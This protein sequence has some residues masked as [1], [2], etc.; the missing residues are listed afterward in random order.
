MSATQRFS[1]N[2]RQTEAYAKPIALRGLKLEP[3]HKTKLKL[4]SEINRLSNTSL[5]AEQWSGNTLLH[6]QDYY[7][8]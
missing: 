3:Q 4:L 5:S 6:I 2:T 8:A 1:V 7:K